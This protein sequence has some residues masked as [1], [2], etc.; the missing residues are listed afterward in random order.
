MSQTMLYLQRLVRAP[1]DDCR[2]LTLGQLLHVLAKKSRDTYQSWHEA[3][4]RVLS[5]QELTRR[6]SRFS[7]QG[8]L[9]TLDSLVELI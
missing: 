1:P 8:S 7:L 2:M 9:L 5:L 4:P 6:I 3:N